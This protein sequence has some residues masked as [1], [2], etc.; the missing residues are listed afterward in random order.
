[1][2]TKFPSLLNFSQPKAHFAASDNTK[3]ALMYYIEDPH[4]NR[5]RQAKMFCILYL[6]IGTKVHFVNKGASSHQII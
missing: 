6:K 2:T 5:F 3:H 1:M 4:I